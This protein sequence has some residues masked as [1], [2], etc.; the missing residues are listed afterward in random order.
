MVVILI[1]GF[2]PKYDPRQL[3]WFIIT[4]KKLI[5]KLFLPVKEVSGIAFWSRWRKPIKLSNN[6]KRRIRGTVVWLVPLV[7]PFLNVRMSL[8]PSPSGK[9][10][11]YIVWISSCSICHYSL[12]ITMDLLDSHLCIYLFLFFRSRMTFICFSVFQEAILG[13]N[14]HGEDN[15][16]GVSITISSNFFSPNT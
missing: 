4:L 7:R 12:S 10:G 8:V 2:H 13:Q 9:P 6:K 14:Y 15:H 11:G 5:V 16:N 3:D 1:F